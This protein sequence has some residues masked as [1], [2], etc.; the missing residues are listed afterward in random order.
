MPALASSSWY[1]AISEMSVSE[2]NAP[3]SH[4]RVAFTR[5]MNFMAAPCPLRGFLSLVERPTPVSTR[6]ARDFRDA[7]AQEPLL[8]LLLRKL[9]R[10]LVRHPGLLPPPQPPAEVR[11]GGV[12]Q[13]VPREVAAPEDCVD[14]AQARGRAVAHSHRDGSVQ[15]D[16]G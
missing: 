10:L 6:S 8:G 3:S 11:P 15:L 7:P 5:I 12:G 13:V 1:A 2:G 9:Q 14:E 16:H 4:S